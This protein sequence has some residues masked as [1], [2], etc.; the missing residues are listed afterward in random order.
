MFQINY[1]LRKFP[2][3]EWSGILVY[4]VLKGDMNNL[5]ELTFHVKYVFLGDIGSAGYTEFD[6]TGDIMYL[7]DEY[8]EAV[9][10]RLGFI[11][12]HHNMGSG[13]SGTDMEELI[14]NA[15]QHLYYL[16]LI[17]THNPNFSAKLAFVGKRMTNSTRTFKNVDDTVIV[18][19]NSSST[20]IV[21]IADVDVYHEYN[22]VMENRIKAVSAIVKKR[23][24][25][26]AVIRRE[27]AD[28]SKRSE[29]SWER[30]TLF[31][32]PPLT[33]KLPKNGNNSKDKKNPEDRKETTKRWSPRSKK[34]LDI[35]DETA[36]TE[37]ITYA[38]TGECWY[39][40][41]GLQPII[42]ALTFIGS[43]SE[44]EDYLDNLLDLTIGIDASPE[45]V[46]DLIPNGIDD[47]ETGE[48]LYQAI[49]EGADLAFEDM[50]TE[51][52]SPTLLND[53]KNIIKKLAY[54]KLKD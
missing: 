3:N 49:C 48:Y 45:K 10:M 24:E 50:A 39:D 43:N 11:H 7:F 46:M 41:E 8:P 18:D 37:A 44:R 30:G 27:I 20:D 36:A 51:G 31:N 19:N 15:P 26:S 40:F 12:S 2:S 6:T 22:E 1:L 32:Q 16:S 35:I 52:F 42:L 5:S 53:T 38:L 29:R 17:V 25:E 54:E 14:E 13:F 23:E 33:G 4:K 28:F 34:F 21:F 47:T 9:D